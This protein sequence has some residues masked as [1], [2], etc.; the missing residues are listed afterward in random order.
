[1]ERIARPFLD[2]AHA[3]TTLSTTVPSYRDGTWQILSCR[4]AQSRRRIS[5]RLLREGGLWLGVVWQLEVADCDSGRSGEQWLYGRFY[6]GRQHL[7]HWRREAAAARAEPRF[8]AAV[9]CVPEAGLVL[10]ALPND[11]SMGQLATFLEPAAL[12]GHLPSALGPGLAAGTSARIVRHEAEEHCTARF[13]TVRGGQPSAFYGKCYADQRWLGAHDGLDALWRQAAIDPQAFAVGRPLGSSAELGTVWQDEVRGT[14]LATVLHGSGGGE[15]IV[16][17]AEALHRFQAD[18]PRQ[19]RATSH[20]ESIELAA[21]WRKKLLLAEPALAEATDPV[22]SLLRQAPSGQCRE[23]PVHGDFHI[24]QMSWNGERIALFDYDNLALGSPMRDLA[25]CI[26]QLLCRADEG[27]WRAIAA[28]LLL[29]Y[30]AGCNS[31]FDDRDFEWHL[32]LMLMRKAYSFLVRSRRGWREQ[33]RRA[34]EMA[35]AGVEALSPA[36]QGVAA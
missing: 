18:G 5:R 34:L 27:H 20:S 17:L 36:P 14:A 9:D 23:V 11:P 33:S 32:R 28:R 6:H 16:R 12:A 35:L 4:V 22:L 3:A 8:A 15:V 30:L 25:D 2:D 1:M 31:G 13:Q 21:K 26:S 19:G 24:D 29:A 7:Q 10:W